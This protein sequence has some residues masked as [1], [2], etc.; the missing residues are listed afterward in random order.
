MA[1]WQ[2]VLLFSKGNEHEAGR[3]Q[4]DF[5]N[6]RECIKEWFIQYNPLRSFKPINGEPAANIVFLM[7]VTGII[8]N[9]QPLKCC[10]ICHILLYFMMFLH[11]SPCLV[12]E[13][14][15]IR[16]ILIFLRGQEK[17][18]SFHS[19]FI[20]FIWPEYKNF[21]FHYTENSLLLET[22]Q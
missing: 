21:P 13:D 5:L 3:E 18:L 22:R 16:Q 19:E 1:F 8:V 14:I 7:A 20:L 10:D 4:P 17:R 12:N 6:R 15:I 2:L 9:S 11:T